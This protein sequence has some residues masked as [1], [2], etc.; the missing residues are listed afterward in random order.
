MKLHLTLNQAQGSIIPINYQYPLASGIYKIIAQG[1]ADYAS[2]LHEHAYKK[3]GSLKAFKLFTFS[4][5]RSPFQI[6]GDRLLLCSKESIVDVC[7]HIPDAATH[8]VRGLFVD[9]VIEI[10]DRK[11]KA[12]F[13][14]AQVEVVPLWD[15]P[16]AARTSKQVLLRPLSPMVIGRKNVRGY[17]DYLSPHDSDFI[18]GL[19]FSWKEKYA[20]VYGSA[21]AE[22]DFA[23]LSV[24]VIGKENTRS[25]LI[26]IKEGSPE[27]TKVRGFLGFSLEVQAL[28]EVLELALNAGIG[29]N[30]SMGFGC[31]GLVR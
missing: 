13:D 14:I 28:V 4:D 24:R 10:A 16:L 6:Q 30:C 8:F 27:E 2:F 17:S 21:Q 25:R 3:E 20:T 19:I 18:A 15:E 31:V 1:N 9:Q 22:A 29:M 26:T 23:S 11:S 7:F 5:L 12:R